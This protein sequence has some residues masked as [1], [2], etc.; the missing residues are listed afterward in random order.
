[1]AV[2]S[3]VVGATTLRRRGGGSERQKEKAGGKAV[4]I[5]SWK[6]SVRPSELFS[7]Q[8]RRWTTLISGV[9]R[10]LFCNIGECLKRSI[11]NQ[12]M[13]AD[14]QIHAGVCGAE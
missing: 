9:D 1:M 6:I 2:V 4:R 13:H 3:V 14:L 5:Q 10:V 11:V 12:P 7:S 8:E